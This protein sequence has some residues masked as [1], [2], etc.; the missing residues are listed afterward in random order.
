[1][2]QPGPATVAQVGL[3]PLPKRDLERADNTAGP[4]ACLRVLV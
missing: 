3:N 4:I 1:M 2:A